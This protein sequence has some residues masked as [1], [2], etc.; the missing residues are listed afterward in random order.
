MEYKVVAPEQM[1][2]TFAKAYNSK[3]VE[4]LVR[5]YE[6]EAKLIK[7]D[8]SVAQGLQEI[9]EELTNLIQ[10]GGQ[11]VS[12][13]HFSIEQGEVA[14]LRAN[15]V[16]TTVNEHGEEIQIKGSTSEVVKR[17][18]DGTWLYIIDHPFGANQS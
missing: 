3:N 15:F 5:L 14:L 1:N 7:L 6:P 9:R 18:P 12:E 4:N 13:N 10:L 17:Q 16:V 8:G 2:A 11:M